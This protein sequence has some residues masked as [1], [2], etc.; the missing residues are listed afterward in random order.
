MADSN[1][2]EPKGPRVLIT[3]KGR[4]YDATN[5]KRWKDGRH[6]GLHQAGH[7][8]TPELAAAPHGEEV[9]DRLT[10]V[11]EKPQGPAAGSD[12]MDRLKK[13]Y[14]RV[15]PHPI[16]VHLPLGTIP[17]SLVLQLIFLFTKNGSFETAAFY[18]L[19]FA[20][21]GLLLAFPAGL[22]SWWIN[23]ERAWKSVFRKKL[24]FSLILIPVCGLT[25]LVRFC[26]PDVAHQTGLSF[27]FYHLLFFSCPPLA[28][29][30]G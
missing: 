20:W 17:L 9:F 14:Y 25:V 18:A 8:L 13:L 22:L 16:L 29:T 11:E 28:V 5:S 19:A 12:P 21:F 3:Y 7:D 15:H 24:T 30:L 27:F 2:K 6:M 4:T 23:Y 26:F 1:P 10:I